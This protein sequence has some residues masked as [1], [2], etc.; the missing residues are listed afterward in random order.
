MNRSLRC[1]LAAALVVVVAVSAVGGIPPGAVSAQPGPRGPGATA[2]KEPDG[3]LNG[4]GVVRVALVGDSILEGAARRIEDAFRVAGIEAVTDTAVSRSTLAGVE[5]VRFYAAMG[6]DAVVVMLGANDAGNPETFRT[7]VTDVVAAA[8]DVPQLYW[9]TIPEVRDY[10]PAA[11]EVL[12][13]VLGAR[14]G[15]E[16]LDWSP[17]ATS[18]GVT[19]GD[20]LHLSPGG[21]EVMTGFVVSSVV[22]GMIPT[23]GDDTAGEPGSEAATSPS[24]T[25]QRPG[26]PDSGPPDRGAVSSTEAAGSSG[27]PSGGTDRTAGPADSIDAVLGGEVLGRTGV[28]LAVALIVLALAGSGLGVALWSLWSTRP[29]VTH[30]G[31]TQDVAARSAGTVD[32]PE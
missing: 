11:N 19:A 25:P 1:G 12:R 31:S 28:R 6:A 21:V 20:G 8:E 30:V 22:A 10:Y 24:V 5:L 23:A 3:D 2:E 18:N 9:I 14:P 4:D 26:G 15:G 32:D 27:E 16:V 13:E 17:V 29:L 7:R